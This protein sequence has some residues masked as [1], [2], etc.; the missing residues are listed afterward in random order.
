MGTRRP[1]QQ[2][3]ATFPS[4]TSW[5]QRQRQQPRHLLSTS[6]HRRFPSASGV[7]GRQLLPV[8][9][10]LFP[11]PLQRRWPTPRWTAFFLASL[12]LALRRHPTTTTTRRASPLCR[13]GCSATT[14]PAAA[15]R[16]EWERVAARAAA[17]AAADHLVPR[18]GAIASHACTDASLLPASRQRQPAARSLAAV[19]QRWQ[20][21]DGRQHAG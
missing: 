19:G 2:P 10:H 21:C 9:T 7:H 5:R 1:R 20:G 12:F 3:A 14:T 17:T 18:A 15:A 13:T 4:A 8:R 11:L 16:A 6:Y